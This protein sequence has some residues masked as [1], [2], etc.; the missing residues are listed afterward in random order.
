MWLNPS[1]RPEAASS[2]TIGHGAPAPRH[3]QAAA[4]RATTH[5]PPPTIAIIPVTGP[6]KRARSAGSIAA[7][8]SADSGPRATST[9]PLATPTAASK[10]G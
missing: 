3:A 4:S 5:A 10:A 9:T 7:I 6:Q 1:N 8:P 2:A